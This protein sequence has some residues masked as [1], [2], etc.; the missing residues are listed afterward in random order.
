MNGRLKELQTDI[1]LYILFTALSLTIFA[2]TMPSLVNAATDSIQV[3]SGKKE[4]N[5][6]SP[7]RTSSGNI[8]YFNS[9][10]GRNY[11]W[12]G[13]IDVFSS[14]DGAAWKQVS[15]HDGA[16]RWSSAGF[17]IDSANVIHVISYNWDLH[18]Y[19][20]KFN[21]LDSQRGDHS[22]EGYQLIDNLQGTN[23]SSNVCAIAIDANDI[24]HVVYSLYESYKGKWYTTLYYANRSGG[25]WNKKT[26]VPKESRS[27]SIIANIA[28]GPYNIPY[29]RVGRKILKGNSNTPTIFE[30]KD[31]GTA[32]LSFVIHNNGDIRVLLPVSNIYSYY[33][34]DHTQTWNS[35]WTL[36]SSGKY[37]YPGALT[38]VD[39]IPYKIINS[40]SLLLQ[41]E[42]EDP[43]NIF[44]AQSGH[45][46]AIPRWSFYNHHFPDI[47]DLALI[48]P[49]DTNYNDYL[50]AA[51]HTRTRASFTAAPVKGIAP[52]TVNFTDTS[53]PKDG[54]EIL[55]WLW[56]FN[57][58]NVV[59]SYERNP[60]GIFTNPGKYT[61]KL[62][63]TDSLGNTDTDVSTDYITADG[64]V[65]GDGILDSDDNCPSAYNATQIDMDHD[66]IGDICDNYIDLI[67]QAILST[68]LKSA[69]SSEINVTDVT[70]IMKDGLLDQ[71]ERVQKGKKGY[72]VLSFRSNVNAAQINSYLL[73]I[74]VNSL[75]GGTP[76]TVRI[77]AYIADGLTVQKSQTL[78]FTLYSGWNDLDLTPLL[79]LMDGFDFVKFRLAVDQNWFDISEAWVTAESAVELDYR[80]ISV[81]PPSLDFG[82]LNIGDYTWSSFNVSNSG[83]GALKIGAIPT[84]PLPFSKYSDACSG[85]WLNSSESCT[86]LIRVI[87]EADGVYNYILEVPSNDMDHQNTSVT[88]K[89]VI[90]A[91]SVLTGIVTDE[92]TGV[93][94]SDVK[95]S[96]TMP[97]TVNPL[98]E[99]LDFSMG[100][101]LNNN[102]NDLSYK[103][104]PADYQAVSLNDDNKALGLSSEEYHGYGYYKHFISLF[105]L[106]N[107]F[108][109][110]AKFKV[111]W[112]GVAGIVY[113]ELLGQSFMPGKSGNLT[114]VSVPLSA[115]P[116]CGIFCTGGE[117]ATGNVILFL[118]SKLGG[119]KEYILA[120]S[121]PVPLANLT[122]AA[123]TWFDFQFSNTIA[124]VQGQTYYL[125]LHTDG[126]YWNNVGECIS[127]RIS[128]PITYPNIYPRGRGFVRK[129][130]IWSTITALDYSYDVSDWSGTFQ[131]YI[132]DQI[133]QQNTTISGQ[134]TYMLGI[135]H[136]NVYLDLYDRNI[137]NWVGINQ[138]KHELGYDD[139]TL[140]NSID[141]NMSDYYDAN[142]RLSFVV[143]NYS[144]NNSA[145]AT[146]LF[147][148]EFQNEK[149]TYTDLNG[150]YSFSGLLAGAYSVV[151]NKTGYEP[152]TISGALISGQTQILNVQLKKA[153]PLTVKI[154]VPQDGYIANSL[155]LYV[156]GN[157]SNNA[158]V[159]VNSIQAHLYP[160]NTYYADVPIIEGQNI[161]TATANDR[162]GQTASHSITVTYINTKPPIISNITAS[163]ITTNSAVISW[164]TD[165]PSDSFVQYGETTGYGST[166]SNA[167]L[168]TT[169]SIT[170]NNLSPNKTY[171][172]K[173]ASK[174]AYGASSS[175]GDNTFITLIPNPPVISNITLTDTTTNSAIV[176]WTTDQQTSIL[177]EYGITN[178]YGS[179]VSDSAA[180]TNHSIRI[181]NL[182]AGT[183][184]HFR[185]TAT[186]VYG[187]S[188]SSQDNTFTTLSPI[189]V[190]IT[191]P[192]N[193][194]IINMPDVM[195]KG[196]ITNPTGNET[197]VTVNG[198]V[199]T[200]YGNQFIANHVPLTEGQNTITVTATDT[201]GNAVSK[202]VSVNAITT[203]NYI[204][205][206]SNI[207]SGIAPLQ[208]TLRIDGSFS[209]TASDISVTGPGH[210]E[211]LPGAL[212]DEYEVVITTEGVYYFS[213]SVTGP[214]SIVYQDT[215]AVTVLNK[216]EMDNMLKGKWEGMI[217][218]LRIGDMTTALNNITS[219]TRTAYGEM[220]NA[221]GAQLP[222]IITTQTELNL[223]SIKNHSAMYE[224]VTSENGKRYSYEVIFI[225]NKNGI[226][227]IKEF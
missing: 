36:Y 48:S 217:G 43:I 135:D 189:T 160:D 121:A 225:N 70:A 141:R 126:C 50:F 174:N 172:F 147:K 5:L 93:P 20:E 38:L 179:S 77:S 122:N 1:F 113:H 158:N 107:P 63:V 112:N 59:D 183:L 117:I 118:K 76:Q 162:Y 185:I 190:T 171:H 83:T 182:C 78:S 136:Q 88:L 52:L 111:I 47:I 90:N 96:I 164:T 227:M 202:S 211:F 92:A 15:S 74:Y 223:I 175:S 149:S 127:P 155:P 137:N 132:N 170:L 128:W 85:K 184:Y 2:A 53:V 79:H 150:R 210:V 151:L 28:I 26:I 165:Q 21:T 17:A 55:T 45:F 98:P 142:G 30:E 84:P 133:D 204:R 193:N 178:I 186:N 9:D 99:D 27:S 6:F 39:D 199:A 154:I 215:V 25:L 216:T 131:I 3:S 64:D 86:V 49:Y 19:Y 115:G 209:I 152:K 94:L 221:M 56:D 46:A 156:Y 108:Q 103:F 119:E 58:D 201:T 161:I 41:K 104:T 212:V 73:S 23:W 61:I 34:H 12:D 224:L 196:T 143:H 116:Q 65:D 114:K 207:E 159:T 11:L 13:Y 130:V 44:S 191:S 22:W 54:A 66:G 192:S 138:K 214:D 157:T 101:E 87:P 206:T 187:S 106:R 14:S 100:T 80:E 31:F 167:G 68:G 197:G 109:D 18:P 140:E 176:T 226:W 218:S 89:G 198:M 16:L 205:L 180:T 81:S 75:Y 97:V 32:D 67:S 134:Y 125:E 37:Q 203:G 51:Y 60:A 24:P 62:S 71:T 220:F 222:Y 124:L 148:V 219:E 110:Y 168:V 144:Y 169:H 95:V 163:N 139:M 213:A 173:A 200:V 29:I 120:E 123:S 40:N 177:I 145:L 166:I 195:V 8:Y 181:P 10:G 188:S 129:N 42:F 146:D 33:V 57:G 35:G 153:P 72:D 7:V 69:T 91:P 194:E 105:K 4:F 102:D 208:V 82:S